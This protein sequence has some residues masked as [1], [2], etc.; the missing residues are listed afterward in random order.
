V[1]H[2][3]CMGEIKIAYHILVRKPDGERLLG[4]HRH[5]WSDMCGL[6][7]FGSVQGPVVVSY[8]YGNE[9]LRSIKGREFFD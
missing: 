8:E 2:V 4:R 1:G 5:S 7:S 6:D 9:P 3:V